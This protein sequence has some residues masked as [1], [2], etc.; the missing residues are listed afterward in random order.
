[1]R[2]LAARYEG[3]LGGERKVLRIENGYFLGDSH[4]TINKAAPSGSARTASS[5]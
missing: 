3:N 1:M 2:V 4:L 5:D